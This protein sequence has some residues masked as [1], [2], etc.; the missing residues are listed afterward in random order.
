MTSTELMPRTNSTFHSQ[1][2]PVGQTGSLNQIR[3]ADTTSVS[4]L[5]STTDESLSQHDQQEIFH[6]GGILEIVADGFGV[7]RRRH[8]MPDSQDI[9]V[10]ASQIRRFALRLGDFVEGQARPPKDR[11]QFAGLLRVESVNGLDPEVA[12]KRPRFDNLTPVF[13]YEQFDLET[14]SRDLSGRVINL[15]SPLG[16]GQRALIVAPP[17]AGKTILL[18]N[19]ANAIAQRYPDVHIMIA[20]IG[21]RPEEV[22]DL[23]RVINAEVISSTFDEPPYQHTRLAE[24]ILERAKRLVEGGQDVVILMDSLTR[25]SRAYNLIVEP[26]GRSLSGGLDPNALTLPKRFFGA[27][28][29][30]EEGGSLT[31]IATT[32][33]ETGSR[34]DDVIYEEFKGTGNME[35]VLSRKLAE[36]RIFPAVDITLSGTRREEMLYDKPTYRAAITM[37]RMFEQLS[38]QRGIEAVEALYQQMA[39]TSNNK[40]FLATLGR[41]MA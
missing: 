30:L 14:D 41:Q 8:F 13:P 12:R 31:I 23:Q 20:L 32:L 5:H 29:K 16:R 1:S 36:R 21:E 3:N 11:E 33:I 2:S 10:S 22:T 17:K 24:M 38:A 26:S 7:L 25:L 9:Y 27:A 39:K 37:R 19:I 15:V 28:R 18:T 4:P 6:G 35:L 40:E 34:M